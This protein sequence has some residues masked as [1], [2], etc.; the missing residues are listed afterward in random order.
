VVEEDLLDR[1]RVRGATVLDKDAWSRI[2]SAEVAAGEARGCQRQKL[3]TR[4]ALLEA[5]LGVAA[6]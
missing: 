3:P 5:G 4:E 6:L 2:D 1:L